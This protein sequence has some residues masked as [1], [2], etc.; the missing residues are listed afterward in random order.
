MHPVI[1]DATGA[2]IAV[3]EN[4]L[5]AAYLPPASTVRKCLSAA[6]ISIVL[7]G[8]VREWLRLGYGIGGTSFFSL[9]REQ[10]IGA[11]FSATMLAGCALI[12]LTAGRRAEVMQQPHRGF[13]FVLAATFLALSIDEASSVHESVMV[14]IQTALH[15]EGLFR[16]AWVVPALVMVPLFALMSLPFLFSLP[17]RTA[18]WFVGSGAVYVSGALGFEM[19]EGQTDGSGVWFV[20][21]YLIEETLEITGILSFLFSLMDYVANS[22]SAASAVDYVNR[23]RAAR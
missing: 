15:S 22:P 23:I 6:A 2:R 3:E 1:R 9:N 7:L 5:G 16:Y 11:W 19:I 17:R 12:L 8:C 4:W 14:P 10:N 18:L 21:C 13:W 20:M